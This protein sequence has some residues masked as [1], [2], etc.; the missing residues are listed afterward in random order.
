MYKN[1]KVHTHMKRKLALLIAVLFPWIALFA[2][3]KPAGALVALFLQVTIIG[4]LPASIWA[5]KEVKK[6]MPKT[7][8]RA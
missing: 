2:C 6:T 5:I 7:K 1:L 3:D 8:K 4:W